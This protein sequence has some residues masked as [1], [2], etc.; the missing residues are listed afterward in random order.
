MFL[1]PLTTQA[2]RVSI[3]QNINHFNINESFISE[4]PAGPYTLRSYTYMYEQH[5]WGEGEGFENLES[6][7]KHVLSRDRKDLPLKVEMSLVEVP[8]LNKYYFI[9]SKS[10]TELRSQELIEV[11]FTLGSWSDYILGHDV[12]LVTVDRRQVDNHIAST[13]SNHFLLFVTQ[14]LAA[15][16]NLGIA[17]LSMRWSTQPPAEQSVFIVSNQGLSIESHTQVPQI[18]TVIESKIAKTP[19]SN[20]DRL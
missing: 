2:Q 8:N 15:V 1:V 9:V 14:R 13:L 5:I 16:V 20:F 11:Q 4:R 10:D 19:R 17:Q 7:R 18:H 3:H 6:V 12:Q